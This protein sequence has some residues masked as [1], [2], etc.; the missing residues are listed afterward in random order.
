MG[1]GPGRL[2]DEHRVPDEATVGDLSEEE[3]LARIGPLVAAE[4]SA[5]VLLGPGDDTAWLSTPSGAVLATTDS[6]IRGVDWRDD[7][8]TG[9]HVG[10]KCV[11]QNVADIASM[12]GR[13][14]ALLVALALAPSTPLAWVE[15]LAAGIGGAAADA[16]VA[17][18]GGDLSGAPDGVIM[19]AMTALGELPESL[20][21][22]GPVRRSGACVGDIVAVCGSLGYSAAG[23]H[24]LH[25][26]A[27]G[28]S[29][30]VVVST[31]A[32]TE[33]TDLAELAG[34][35]NSAGRGD[36]ADRADRVGTSGRFEMPGTPPTADDLI[37]YHVAPRPPYEAGP[38]AGEHGASAMIDISDGLVRDA[39]RI[40][41]ASAVGVALDRRLLADDVATLAVTVGEDVAWECL[42][43]GGEEHALLAT[44]PA[45]RGLPP[46]W[47]R[48]GT[49]TNADEPGVAIDGEPVR[50]AGWDH[51][52]G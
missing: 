5:R 1:K 49:V 7:W 9:A 22:S 28:V 30:A 34:T 31:R 6:M 11:A 27:V 20:A 46:G 40:A 36:S 13:A 51:F 42:L 26:G 12:A 29:G 18:V 19:V 39:A 44:F 25:R 17:V 14:T 47:R 4:P 48:I 15:D 35:E 33:A 41:A 52:A 3:I 2:A 50:A 43:S 23:L 16:G 8:S 38:S 32:I 37:R 24:L 45:E 10:A 21:T